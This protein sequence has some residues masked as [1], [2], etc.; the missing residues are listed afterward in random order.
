VISWPLAF[1]FSVGADF[2][3]LRAANIVINFRISSTAPDF[4]T[5]PSSGH[6]NK[7]TAGANIHT[8]P[9]NHQA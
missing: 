5:L 6:L 3:F 1:H 8:W 7:T 9:Y 4:T 2:L